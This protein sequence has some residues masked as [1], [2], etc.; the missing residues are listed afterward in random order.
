MSHNFNL[1]HEESFKLLSDNEQKEFL[2][3]CGIYLYVPMP[4]FCPVLYE[5]HH[6]NENFKMQTWKFGIGD[7]MFYMKK[8][9]EFN[10]AILERIY[11][12]LISELED[13]II[14][15]NRYRFEEY[16]MTVK[17]ISISNQEL[18]SRLERKRELVSD[19]YV[20]LTLEYPEFVNGFTNFN[21]Y[22][23][24][25]LKQYVISCINEETEERVIED[26]LFNR[27]IFQSFI[28]KIWYKTTSLLQEINF[29]K[30]QI[31]KLSSTTSSTDNRIELIFKKD[32]YQLFDFIVSHYPSKKDT[33]FFSYLFFYLKIKSE[34]LIISDDSKLYRNFIVE[35][36]GLLSYSRIQKTT[37]IKEITKEKKTFELLDII[38]D[39]FY[40]AKIE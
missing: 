4:K 8:T 3:E 17:S 32:G 37:S 26:F 25:S 36:Y 18:I 19:E 5:T 14:F 12:K 1:L 13:N 27:D 2:I 30:E 40:S 9:Y 10:P 33:A 16:I 24:E 15:L 39:K 7:E 6:Y 22:G 21:V 28:P 20:N 31:I 11:Q 23:Y 29:L 34:I 38:S 35:N